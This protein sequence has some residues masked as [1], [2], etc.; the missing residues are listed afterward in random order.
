[1]YDFIFS[2]F[3]NSTD[4]MLL[5]PTAREE[6]GRDRKIPAYHCPAT[7]TESMSFRFIGRP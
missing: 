5:Y 4:V 3:K 7:V 2:T 1:M 6:E